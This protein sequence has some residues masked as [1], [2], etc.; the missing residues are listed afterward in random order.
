MKLKL[1]GY[2]GC[3]KLTT[4]YFC[5]KHKEKRDAER[6]ASAFKSATRSDLYQSPEWR[7]I[8][9]QLINEVGHCERCGSFD[10]LQ[11]HHI[12]P[13]RLAPALALDRSNLQVLCRTCHQTETGKEIAARRN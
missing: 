3:N 1:C 7:R 6:K 13:V 8:S 5:P 11:V 12:I 2:P 9:R 4:E 10:N